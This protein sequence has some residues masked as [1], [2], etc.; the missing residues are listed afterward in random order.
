[1]S[2]KLKPL[3]ACIFAFLIVFS[4]AQASQATTVW[5]FDGVKAQYVKASWYANGT[6][7]TK[8]TEG[9]VPHRLMTVTAQGI[10]NA[11]VNGT[12][13]KAVSGTGHA[14]APYKT[15]SKTHHSQCWWQYANSGTSNY[16]IRCAYEK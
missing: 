15:A 16:Q 11:G 12:V 10:T 2:R 8:Q 13:Y 14:I 9:F 5:F 6:T 7:A 3:V 1:M 4:T